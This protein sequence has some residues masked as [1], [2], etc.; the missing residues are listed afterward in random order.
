MSPQW[1]YIAHLNDIVKVN[2][3][4]KILSMLLISD[5]K[6]MAK[7]IILTKMRK[8]MYLYVVLLSRHDLAVCYTI[9]E[10]IKFKQLSLNFK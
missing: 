5:S 9:Y 7:V 3:F 4:A 2:P 6:G 1:I 8:C 10:Q